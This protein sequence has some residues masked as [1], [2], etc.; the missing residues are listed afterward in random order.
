[1]LQFESGSRYVVTA[2][3]DLGYRLVIHVI[4]CV[5]KYLCAPGEL[6]IRF[7]LYSG[8][9]RQSSGDS[10]LVVVPYKHGPMPGKD[11]WWALYHLA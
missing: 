5:S 2:K 7:Q 9:C 6:P 10:T 11:L 8:L 3:T 1:M 4:G